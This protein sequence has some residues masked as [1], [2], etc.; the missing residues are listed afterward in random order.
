MTNGQRALNPDW[1][2]SILCTE[3]YRL[4]RRGSWPQMVMSRDYSRYKKNSESRHRSFAESRKKRRRRL[5]RCRCSEEVQLYHWKGEDEGNVWPQ[6]PK[7]VS[8][9]TA[10][11]RG[12]Q[13]A[14]RS[15]VVGRADV[16]EVGQK[17]NETAATG[18]NAKYR[19][20]TGPSDRTRRRQVR[21]AA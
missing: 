2:L 9:R 14:N 8:R 10:H 16:H 19:S 18:E 12:I 13:V 17:K 7:S 11:D 20:P 6:G 15:K 5:N 1:R 4:G 21:L 3:A